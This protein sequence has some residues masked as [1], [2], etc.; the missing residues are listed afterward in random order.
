MS[1]PV[2]RPDAETRRAQLLDAADAVF[3]THGVN[4]PLEL[5]V[6]HAGVGRATLYR[7]YP[8]RHAILLALME[9]SVERLQAKATS[10]SD[11]PEA[12]FTL[13]EYLAQRIV[14]SPAIS[15]YWRTTSMHDARFQPARLQVRKIFAPA[16]QR[17]QAHGLVRKDIQT[18]DITLLS[19]MLGAALRGDTEAERLRLARQ[20]L[21]IIRRGLSPD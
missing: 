20:A 7:Q 9:R 10:L 19:G 18:S 5:V 1:S 2:K 14:R 11:A 21:Q 16:L 8:D 4:A 3:T 17:A 6:E 15:D 13:L 12:F